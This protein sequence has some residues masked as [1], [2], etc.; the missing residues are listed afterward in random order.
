M[1]MNDLKAAL[2]FLRAFRGGTIGPT[3]YYAGSTAPFLVPPLTILAWLYV[4]LA[5]SQAH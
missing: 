2:S 4:L 3:I 1:H 5:G